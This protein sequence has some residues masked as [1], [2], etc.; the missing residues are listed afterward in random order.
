VYIKMTQTQ[1]EIL[2]QVLNEALYSTP[3]EAVSPTPIQALPPPPPPEEDDEI[4]E[5]S[6]PTVL[7]LNRKLDIDS[8]IIHTTVIALWIIIW[9]YSGLMGRIR[10]QVLLGLVF[11]IFIAY[12]ISSIFTAGHSS[13]GV[14]Y[15][16]NILLTVEQMVSIL[17]GTIVLFT[18]FKKNLS[19][20]DTCQKVI[21]TICYS[22]IIILTLASS[23]VSIWTSGRA[24]RAI[25][26]A[27]QGLYN[28]TLF[29]FVVVGLI[30]L[31]SN[32]SCILGE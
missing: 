14:V 17:F 27:K 21:N 12:N 19:M 22:M 29:L 8:I 25:R 32:D 26:K 7:F 28:I 31:K 13:G 2:D 3:K 16:L 4:I 11:I 1:Q 20:T 6:N 5:K 23:W 10:T 9:W 30:L 15:E 18:L 24:F